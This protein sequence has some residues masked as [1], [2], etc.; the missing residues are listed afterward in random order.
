MLT[1]CERFGVLVAVLGCELFPFHIDER[2]RCAPTSCSPNTF[3]H[4]LT[5]PCSLYLLHICSKRFHNTSIDF[6]PRGDRNTILSQ[7]RQ[8]F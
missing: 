5:D 1:L 3:E 2:D 4:R 7:H 8:R 6:L